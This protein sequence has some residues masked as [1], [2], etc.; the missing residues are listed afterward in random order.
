MPES[1][2]IV[3]VWVKPGM[4]EAF[5]KA[6]L[7]NAKCSVKEEGNLRF[8][9]M[10]EKDDRC[11]FTL[12]EVYATAQQAAKHKE[13]QHYLTWRATVADMMAQPRQAFRQEALFIQSRL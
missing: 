10:Q 13:T 4:E 6:T 9:F 3:S 11:K 7:A 12:V 1:A 8:D 2:V 5:I